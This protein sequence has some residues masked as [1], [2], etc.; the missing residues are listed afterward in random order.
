MP[1]GGLGCGITE[2]EQYVKIVN[3]SSGSELSSAMVGGHININITGADEIKGPIESGDIVPFNSMSE[4]RSPPSPT[5]SAPGTRHRFLRGTWRGIFCR[6]DTPDAW[7]VGLHGCGSENSL[8]K[9][10]YQEF[11]KNA[12]YLDR[13][14]YADAATFQKLIDEEYMHL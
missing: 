11:L 12:S 2:V 3:Y 4:N 6:K 7:A 14:G 9:P 13:E 1:A 10:E 8:G 5:W